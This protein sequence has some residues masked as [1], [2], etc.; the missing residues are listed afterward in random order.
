MGSGHVVGCL[1]YGQDK[2]KHDWVKSVVEERCPSAVRSQLNSYPQFPKLCIYSHGLTFLV[3]HYCDIHQQQP[4]KITPME[5]DTTQ[6][7]TQVPT[8]HRIL[9]PSYS[10]VLR[11]ESVGSSDKFLPIYHAT[12]CHIP[13]GQNV[14]SL[15]LC[16]SGSFVI[17]KLYWTLSNIITL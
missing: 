17:S 10:S 9:L 1:H 7:V 14:N 12:Q 4:V 16:D 3:Q 2:E 15:K 11:M 13:I 5:C 8:M 6:L